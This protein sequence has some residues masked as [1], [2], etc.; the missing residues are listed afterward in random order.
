MPSPTPSV[1]W[2]RHGC[3]KVLDDRIKGTPLRSRAQQGKNSTSRRRDSERRQ[4][5]SALHL[6][7]P[8]DLFG[9]GEQPKHWKTPRRKQGHF[10]SQTKPRSRNALSSANLDSSGAFSRAYPVELKGECAGRRVPQGRDF[11]G[12]FARFQLKLPPHVTDGAGGGT[13]HTV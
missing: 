5:A 11:L 12:L 6:G 1:V 2:R 7:V 9:E 4:F 8:V 13:K 3:S 10:P